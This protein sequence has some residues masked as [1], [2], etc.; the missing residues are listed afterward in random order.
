MLKE[1]DKYMKP[2]N[3]NPHC[4][5]TYIQHVIRKILYVNKIR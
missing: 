4:C 3:L 1:W 5:Y 2:N